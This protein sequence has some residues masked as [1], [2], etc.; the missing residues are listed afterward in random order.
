MEK[1]ARY[2]DKEEKTWVKLIVSAP[3]LE[4]ISQVASTPC[5]PISPQACETIAATL[6]A[7]R[8]AVWLAPDRVGGIFSSSSPFLALPIIMFYNQDTLISR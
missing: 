8:L 7:M 6:R 4:R 3:L 1:L 5:Q 2:V